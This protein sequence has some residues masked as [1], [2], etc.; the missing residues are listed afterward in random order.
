[1]KQGLAV[2]VTVT[3]MLAGCGG[4]APDGSARSGAA[5]RPVQ[6][7]TLSVPPRGGHCV[8][9]TIDARRVPHD[10]TAFS[11]AAG[12]HFVAHGWLVDDE[13]QSPDTFQLV[14]VDQGGRTKD[15]AGT[16]GGL[17]TDVARA[18][19]SEAAALA[20]YDVTVSLAGMPAGTYTLL[21]RIPGAG[22]GLVCD[23]QVKLAVAAA[24]EL[25]S[26]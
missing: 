26:S 2:A 11:V 18:M 6:A 9:D 17:R 14:L 25:A 12:S 1:M 3:L 10:G 4:S 22:T 5:G 19:R 7:T 13:A 8:L 15:F 21:A 23:L 16:T 24:G 20:G